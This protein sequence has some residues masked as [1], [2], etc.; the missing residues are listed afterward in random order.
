M[1]D[2]LVKQIP[3][4]RDAVKQ[5][6]VVYFEQKGF[7]ADDI[8]ATLTK[9]ALDENIQVVIVSA[10]KDILQLVND[11]VNV[12]VEPKNVL[13]DEKSVEEKYGF[14]PNRIRDFLALTGDSSD[15]IPGVAGV[16]KVTALNLIKKYGGVDDILKNIDILDKKYKKKIVENKDILKLSYELVKL[17][18]DLDI[19]FDKLKFA[20]TGKYNTDNFRSFLEEMEFHAIIKSMY[21]DESSS[22][23]QEKFIVNDCLP[24]TL[25]DYFS[26]SLD[27]DANGKI[28]NIVVCDKN[29]NIYKLAIDKYSDWKEKFKSL[30][31]RDVK[32]YVE[33]LKELCNIFFYIDLEIDMKN[34]YDVVVLDICSTLLLITSTEY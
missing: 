10:D 29:K 17:R 6:G 2:E 7:E 9:K 13:F 31:N 25:E 14:L 24:E 28:L 5:M 4:V 27:K 30:L 15:N 26:V 20:V 8:I 12:L 19:D 33:N 23:Q 22:I 16:G 1:P 34:F 32:V 11:S 3:F 18:D 21:G